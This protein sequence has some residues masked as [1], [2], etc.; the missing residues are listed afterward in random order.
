MFN[1]PTVI[2][3]LIIMKVNS[4]RF[5]HWNI[6]KLH[7]N[8]KNYDSHTQK[9]SQTVKFLSPNISSLCEITNFNQLKTFD[10]QYKYF[11]KSK[12]T[13]TGQNC[14]LISSIK[15]DINPYMFSNKISKHFISYFTIF[16]VKIALIG[17]HLL[18]NPQS[19]HI[20]NQREKQAL[21][22]Q[23]KI[24]SLIQNNYEILLAGDINDFDNDICDASFSKSYSNVIEIIKNNGNL[25][26]LSKKLQQK[27]R[28]TYNFN[29]K[30]VMIDHIFTTQKLY[31]KIKHVDIYHIKEK[32]I[33][34][35]DHDPI[36]VDFCL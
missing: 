25:I 36:I 15:P 19:M 27:D 3:L 1:L 28:Y 24:K 22:L 5:L 9:I 35:S 6:L 7:K 14:A 33:D 12:D 18:A 26:N 29:N 21:V 17:C 16:N 34:D 31:N 2:F 13:K 23:T 11:V 8:A 20:N 30:N 32:T 4:F 10:F